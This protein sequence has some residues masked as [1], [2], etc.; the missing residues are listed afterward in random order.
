MQNRTVA[1]TVVVLFAINI[2]NFYDRKVTGALAEPM[3]RE[4]DRKSVV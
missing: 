2:L 3:R 4:L 1:F